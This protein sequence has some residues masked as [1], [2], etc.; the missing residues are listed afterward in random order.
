MGRPLTV[1]LNSF[2]AKGWSDGCSGVSLRTQVR[3]KPY[4]RNKFGMTKKGQ[5]GACRCGSE[6][7]TAAGEMVPNRFPCAHA[8]RSMPAAGGR[9]EHR[10]FESVPS[11]GILAEQSCGTGTARQSH[12]RSKQTRKL[13]LFTAQFVGDAANCG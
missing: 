6:T 3:R 2:Q 5:V 9:G 8:R 10:G 1:S 13:L 11:G 12:Y 4:P 7:A